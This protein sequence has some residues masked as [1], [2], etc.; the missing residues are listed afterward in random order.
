MGEKVISSLTNPVL[1]RVRS[2]KQRKYRDEERAFFVEGV[3]PV[4]QAVASGAGIE[5]LIVAP[6]LLSSQAARQLLEKQRAAGTEII[7][8]S[9]QAFS[10]LSQRENP[11]GLGAIVRFEPVKID[12]MT[13][14]SESIYVALESPGNPGNIGT[15]VRTLDA[16]GGGILI[17]IGSGA[18][19]YH[20][21]A[22]KASMGSLFSVP[23][24]HAASTEA[25][26]DWGKLH[27]IQ[28]V[29]T[30]PQAVDPYWS[31]EFTKPLLLL[32]GGEGPGLSRGTLGR[33]DLAVRIP[34]AG[35]ADSLNLAV[36]AG[37]L[38]YEV[39]RQKWAALERV[40]L[41]G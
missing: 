6:P 12:D 20:P 27:G 16:V 22:V 39:E 19:P 10:S 18:D 4:W 28:V 33:G 40:G 30:S 8:V 31:V 13:V 41:T 7:Q 11:S 38:L 14:T 36:A 26:V 34:M 24:T 32:F 23:I 1:K 29:M 5:V 37:V 15:I 21:A 3:R 35:T 25:V 17:L 9:E 2:L